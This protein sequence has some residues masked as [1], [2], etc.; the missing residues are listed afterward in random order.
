M[1]VLVL[2]GEYTDVLKSKAMSNETMTTAYA[3][4]AHNKMMPTHTYNDDSISQYS[5]NS[6]K[7][8]ECHTK[9]LAGPTLLC[10]VTLSCAF[11]RRGD[12]GK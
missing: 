12:G 10:L 7:T 2:K 6:V 4:P 8:T 9:A 5:T 3:T 11:L 1:F